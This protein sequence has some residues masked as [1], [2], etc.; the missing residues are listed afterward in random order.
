MASQTRIMCIYFCTYLV[1]SEARFFFKENLLVTQWK[2]MYPW[3]QGGIY[4]IVHES[5]KLSRKVKPTE[6]FSAGY[7]LRENTDESSKV[8]YN[9]PETILKWT[10]WQ[11]SNPPVADTRQHLVQIHNGHIL[12]V[13]TTAVVSTG[14][15]AWTWRMCQNSRWWI[16]RWY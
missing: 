14:E 7:D 10:V 9:R 2:F 13:A 8:S 5:S 15:S 4:A 3:S 12:A 16:Y 6:T 11:K 1:I